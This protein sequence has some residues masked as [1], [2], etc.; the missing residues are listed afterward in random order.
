MTQLLPTH[1][2]LA[3]LS[4]SSD[5]SAGVQNTA[6]PAESGS[7]IANSWALHFY[8]FEESSWNL[9]S[10]VRPP[11]PGTSNIVTGLGRLSIS[12]DYIFVGAPSEDSDTS[13]VFTGSQTLDQENNDGSD[14]GAVYIYEY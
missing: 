3:I 9:T 7:S 6:A 1:D 4:L 5:G 11:N 14:R 12:Q 10:Y 8:N 2:G 13:G